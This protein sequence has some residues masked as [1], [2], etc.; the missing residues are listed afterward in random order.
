MLD[1]DI[2]FEK[3]SN[4]G[5]NY[6]NTTRRRK[7]YDILY[8][9]QIPNA[10]R[11]TIIDAFGRIENYFDNSD[12][13]TNFI[14]INHLCRELCRMAGYPEYADQF[15]SL[16]TGTRIKKVNRFIVDALGNNYFRPLARLEDFSLIELE[17]TKLDERASYA[18]TPPVYSDRKNAS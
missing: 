15:K 4:N 11:M 17:C 8:S 14:N 13:R 7:L 18:Y 10:L 5:M 3:I 6:V 1:E 2:E 9:V 12:N 16:K